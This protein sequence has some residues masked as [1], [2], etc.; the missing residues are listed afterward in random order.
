MPT[1]SRFSSILHPYSLFDENLPSRVLEIYSIFV[2]SKGAE[3]TAQVMVFCQRESLNMVAR[4]IISLVLE[5]YR[6]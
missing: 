1:L 3:H 2:P 4:A 6:E 5:N